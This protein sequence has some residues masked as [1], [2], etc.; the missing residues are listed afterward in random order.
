MTKGPSVEDP[1]SYAKP[2]HTLPCH[3]KPSQA[4]PCKT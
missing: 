1:F 3:A 4:M 2:S